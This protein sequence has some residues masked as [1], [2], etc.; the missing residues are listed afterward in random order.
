M[1]KTYVSTYIHV[2]IYAHTYIIHTCTYIHG[3]IFGYIL[4]FLTH[5]ELRRYDK[6][7]CNYYLRET[8]NLKINIL[9]VC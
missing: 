2:H 7:Y 1:Q 6:I 9:K 8:Q 3:F 4:S 5:L